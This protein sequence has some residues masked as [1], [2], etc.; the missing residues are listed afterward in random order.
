MR[1]STRVYLFL[2]LL[3]FING[4]AVAAPRVVVSVAPLHG[5]VSELMKGV[6]KP[7]LLTTTDPASPLDFTQLAT[8]ISADMVVWS[9]RSHETA[10]A[11]T[12]ENSLPAVSNKLVTL[13]KI[14][15]LHRRSDMTGDAALVPEFTRQAGFDL[16]FWGDP[17]LTVM[18]VRYITPRLVRID[19]DNSE[20]Y[21]DN[22][23]ALIGRIKNMQ[24][25]I[26]ESLSSV[27]A[28]LLAQVPGLGRYFVHRFGREFSATVGG[29]MLASAPVCTDPSLRKTS[30][31][32]A[33]N[34]AKDNAYF[35][36]MQ[37]KTDTAL[38]YVCRKDV[39]QAALEP[40]NQ[41]RGS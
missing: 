14:L 24:K 17:K 29:E 3:L 15:P 5:L 39:R 37:R 8:V 22:E 16:T 27:D 31:K 34:A 38:S 36:M 21:L 13:S 23:I 6:G 12:V 32:S 10:L 4:F 1:L 18:A 26:A 30:L 2:V 7:Q 19:P 28:R 25:E 35:A 40:G 9:G 33:D 20:K 41:S 11:A